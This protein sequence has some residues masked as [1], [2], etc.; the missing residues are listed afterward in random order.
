MTYECRHIM[1][2]GAKCLS[3][4][5]RGKPYCYYHA[6]L[7]RYTAQ[8][9]IGV[10]GNL[11]LPVLEDRSAIQT[12]LA[13]VLDAMCCSNIDSK[14]AGLLL[15]ALQI[16]GQN[17][18]RSRTVVP[19]ET[20]ETVTETETGDELGPEELNCDPDDC[21]TCPHRATCKECSSDED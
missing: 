19:C 15:Y 20:V 5:M 16:A 6:R 14:R 10:M 13:Q 1:H 9:S 8:P 2:N 3:P 17:V 4:A 12:A 11:K 18:G 7:H 21:P